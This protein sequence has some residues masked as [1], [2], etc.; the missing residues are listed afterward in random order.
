MGKGVNREQRRYRLVDLSKV[1]PE[2]LSD[3]GPK[4]G[5]VKNDKRYKYCDKCRE[6][7]RKAK[8]GRK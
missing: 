2:N 6:A 3:R 1:K 4:C 5:G 7:A 8:A